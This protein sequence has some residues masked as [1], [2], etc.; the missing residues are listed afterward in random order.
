M[1]KNIETTRSGY[2][3]D[4][5]KLRVVKYNWY[6]HQDDSPK[7]LGLIAQ[8][9]EQVFPNLIQHDTVISKREVEQEDGTFVE[10]EFE[11]GTSRSIKVRVLPIM[12]LKA[13]QEQQEQITELKKEIGLL[14]NQMQ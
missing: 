3:D 5:C 14:K 9:V 7:E 1:E 11:D 10:E 8:E 6:N 4:L 2:I 13:I 12:L